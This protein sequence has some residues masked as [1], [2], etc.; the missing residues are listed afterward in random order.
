M[1]KF[2]RIYRLLVGKSGGRG[3]EIKPPLQIEFEVVKDTKP[4]PNTHR[5]KL[6]NL[7]PETIAAVSKPDG[8]CVLYAGYEEDEGE[9]LMAAGGVVD[10][11]TYRE[12]TE[13]ITELSLADGW[14]ELRDTTVSL[15]FGAGVS[16][17]SIIRDVARQ[18][19][20][21]LMMDEKLPNRTWHHGFSFYGAARRALDKITA[22]SGL[23]WSVQNGTLQVVA[24][25]QPTKRQAVVLAADSG[26]VGHPERIR[27]GARDKAVQNAKPEQG[28]S[29]RGRTAASEPRDGWKVTALLLPQINPADI[30]KIESE[31]INDFFR[32]EQV[33][34][35]GS[36][37]GG[38]WQTELEIKEIK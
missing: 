7:A 16:A 36:L 30:V 2:N 6:Y 25:L 1:Y 35:T 29:K 21:S 34:H 4:E 18:M 10:A 23:E 11:Y 15:G 14:V 27:D 3:V 19:G 31:A 32:V 5:V 8:F 37:N 38:D 26:L 12:G 24:K 17:H 9:V 20:L 13:R 22:G 28:K 33:K